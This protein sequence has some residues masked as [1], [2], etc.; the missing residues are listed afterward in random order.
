MAKPD[1][2]I[3]GFVHNGTIY[4]NGDVLNLNTPIHEAS[5]LFTRWAEKNNK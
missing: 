2:T 4:I 3:Y 1:G 5:N